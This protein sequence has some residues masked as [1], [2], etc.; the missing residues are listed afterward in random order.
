[1]KVM[2]VMKKE[3]QCL[4]FFMSFMPFMIFMCAFG[5]RA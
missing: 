5:T 2:K 1:M 3:H 4:F